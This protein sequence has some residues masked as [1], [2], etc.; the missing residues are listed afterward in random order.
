MLL[1]AVPNFSEGRDQALIEE[2]AAAAA[3]GARL[4]DAHADAVHNRVVVS[5]A[6]TDVD[7]L[8][9]GLVGAVRIAAER[10]DLRRHRGVHPRVGAADVMPL[11]PLAGTPMAACVDAAHRLG[12]RIWSEAGVPVFFYGA[13]ALRPEAQRLNHIRVGSMKPDLGSDLHPTAGAVSVGAR[14][15]L[16]AYNLVLPGAPERAVQTLAARVRE[17]SG[18]LPGVQALAFDLGG[19]LMQLSMNLVELGATTPG[20]VLAEAR[21]LAAEMGVRIAAEELVGLCPAAAADTVAADG[22]LLEARLAAA[23]ARGGARRCESRGG[24]ELE[25]LAAR[26]DG[27]GESL[28]ALGTEGDALLRGA[29]EAAALPRVLERAGCWSDD[30]GELFGAAAHGLRAAIPEAVLAAYPE[31]VAALDRWLRPPGTP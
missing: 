20:R 4:L 27:R 29:E 15:P 26:L 12:E 21:R 7:R 10:I 14:P 16:V 18:G 25:R 28:A 22:R 3:S 9:D 8:L 31:R 24:E 11:V 17:S 30:L 1:E 13:A 2:L 6:G 23:A 19:G 5:I